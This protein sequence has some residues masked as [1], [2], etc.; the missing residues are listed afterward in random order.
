M[1]I[2]SWIKDYQFSSLY[3]AGIEWKEVK[4]P[5]TPYAPDADD[6]ISHL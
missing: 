1:V 3:G 6:E 4:E 5:V 2:Y